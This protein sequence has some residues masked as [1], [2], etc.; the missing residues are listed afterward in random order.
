MGLLSSIGSFLGSSGFSNVGSIASSLI[1]G[2]YATKANK[3]TNQTNLQIARETNEQNK[4]LYYANQAWN[5]RMWNLQNSYNS[6]LQQVLRL[7]QAGLNPFLGDIQS[8]EASSVPSSTPPTMQSDAPFIQSAFQNIANTILNASTIQAN[9][10]KTNE[11]IESQRLKNAYDRASMAARLVQIKNEAKSSD[12]RALSDA[13]DSQFN[14]LTF[15]NRIARNKA[16][17]DQAIAQYQAT[18]VSTEGEN[19]QNDIARITKRYLEPQLVANIAQTI[20]QTALTRKNAVFVSAQTLKEKLLSKGIEISNDQARQLVK[21]LVDKAKNEAKISGLQREYYDTYGTFDIGTQG[22]YELGAT[23][24]GEAGTPD[25][26]P[27]GAK[28][29]GEAH[30]SFKGRYFNKVNHRR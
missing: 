2:H 25:W 1:G 17:L 12:S 6:P 4:A 9:V 27:M 22:E 10:K 20:A 19:L 13:L 26:F 7:R 30:G 18:I 21:P 16:E 14:Q 24:G 5:E 15:D 3:L 28:I 23:V 8:G 29:K 11:D